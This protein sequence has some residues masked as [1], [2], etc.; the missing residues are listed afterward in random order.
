M[1]WWVYSIWIW[2]CLQTYEHQIYFCIN[3][4]EGLCD[5]VTWEPHA[6]WGQEALCL[7]PATCLVKRLEKAECLIW[8]QKSLSQRRGIGICFD[9]KW[10]FCIC[11]FFTRQLSVIQTSPT[12]R[13]S[14]KTCP[15]FF[16]PVLRHVFPLCGTLKKLPPPQ[17]PLNAYASM[18][19]IISEKFEDSKGRVVQG[20]YKNVNT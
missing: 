4:L 9:G 20:V 19:Y 14:P 11:S 13:T 8:K 5:S 10:P 15:H 18:F 2:Y 3:A 1:L 6:V 16:A 12:C 7:P 17:S